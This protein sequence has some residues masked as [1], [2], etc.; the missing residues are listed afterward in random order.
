MIV[1]FENAITFAFGV[2]GYGKWI[3]RRR[4][5]KCL[6]RLKV[7]FDGKKANKV[8]GRKQVC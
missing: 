8:L 6:E 3:G 4:V 2:P 5:G 1:L 7:M